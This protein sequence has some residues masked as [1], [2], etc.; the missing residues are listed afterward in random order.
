MTIET[1]WSVCESE[2]GGLFAYRDNTPFY[3]YLFITLPLTPNL[4][5]T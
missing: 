3:L 4:S 5:F 1:V 2:D